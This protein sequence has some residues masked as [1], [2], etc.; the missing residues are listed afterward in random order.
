MA[1][2]LLVFAV[3]A[4]GRLRGRLV[5]IAIP[6]VLMIAISTVFSLLFLELVAPRH[7]IIVF[8]A[9]VLYL[10]LEH[11]R[12]EIRKHNEEDSQSIAEF[13]RMVNI[14]SMF[15]IST[16]GIGLTIFLGIPAWMTLLPLT[17]V[18]IAWS[19]HLYAACYKDCDKP[20]PRILLTTVI[21]VETYL[22]ALR[23]P[24][25]M[26]VGG[27]LVGIVYYLAANLFRA[28]IEGRITVKLVKRYVI[29]GAGLI[30][31]LLLTARWV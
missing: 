31:L 6:A 12:R 5:R 20:W 29:V 11:V 23:L 16:V 15:L 21:V 9:F 14:G 24:T 28:S 22:V 25:S 3:L 30:A 8:F 1:W 2:I 7:G 17:V 27:A 4:I 13:A 10:F 18:A 19:W 26:F